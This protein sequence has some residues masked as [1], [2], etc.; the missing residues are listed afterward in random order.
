[1]SEGTLLQQAR[2]L[3][4]DKQWSDLS[5]LA[6]LLPPF[7]RGEAKLY[8]M[9]AR[10]L[11]YEKRNEEACDLLEADPD[12]AT[13]DED[14]RFYF[15]IAL[16]RAGRYEEGLALL[17][18]VVSAQPRSAK[19]VG[20]LASALRSFAKS[21]GSANE[22]ARHLYQ[23][24]LQATETR[25]RLEWGSDHKARIFAARL[26]HDLRQFDDA[27]GQLE[28]ALAS[29]PQDPD[30]LW[31]RSQCL[32]S[33]GRMGDALAEAKQLL[34]IK[35]AHQGAAY[36]V[37]ILQGLVG[38]DDARPPATVKYLDASAVARRS[39]L[40]VL[41]DLGVTWVTLDASMSLEPPPKALRLAMLSAP[42]WAGRLVVALESGETTEL[43]RAAL[44]QGFSASG[45][46]P[47]S[48]RLA[49]D[50]A[51]LAPIVATRGPDDESDPRLLSEPRGE[52]RRVICM[53]RHGIVR[54]GGGEHFLESMAQHYETLG[55]RPLVVGARSTE[56]A[57]ES[58]VSN[59]REY[60]FLP[61]TDAALRR[62]FVEERPAFV[63]VLS[64]LGYEVAAALEFLSIPFVYG[65]HFWRD[66]LGTNDM[67]TRHFAN[68][69]SDP[70]PRQAFRYVISRAA[71]LYANSAYTQ[72]VLEQAFKFRAPIVY[73]LPG[74]VDAARSG[75]PGLVPGVRDYVLLLNAKPEKGFDLL[76]KVAARLP[77]IPFL[78][79]ASQSS[80]DEAL[81]HVRDQGL[82]NVHIIEKTPRTDLLYRDAL[83]VAVPSYQFI[84]TFSRVCIEAHRFGRP[85][86]GSDKGNVPYLL[87]ESGCVL[88]E[89]ADR[90][91]E[92]IARLHDDPA[93]RER[94]EALARENST[95][96]A[97]A[98]QEA[99]IRGIVGTFGRRVL[100]AIGSGVG[101]MLHAG[102]MIRNIAR[103]LGCKV[104]IVV[105]EEYAD[106]LFLL[107]DPEY[108]NAVFSLGRVVLDRYYDVVLVTS[109]FGD[110][111]PT[112]AGRRVLFARDWQ[113]FEP[114]GPLH[115][116][117]YNLET[118]RV[119]L[120]IEYDDADIEGYYLGEIAW[121][122]GGERRLIGFHGGSKA[123]FWVSKRWP[124]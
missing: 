30:A 26:Y 41:R 124:Y 101:N 74:E 31:L 65:V 120:G 34:T 81:A 109:C 2:R 69:D 59:G 99:S 12:L 86:I 7:R 29:K 111:R 100:I 88:P 55:Y 91:A 37:R 51:A 68:G 119:L 44:L 16:S 20:E 50:L 61:A 108:V 35:P 97:Y 10:G 21:L 25:I 82:T 63:H 90:W 56:S 80:R 43:W 83:A 117:V 66:C 33:V 118:A 116:A 58:G 102:P 84:E 105:A 114:G 3:F 38:S 93:Y 4:K 98:L 11:I 73:S 9:V 75:D 36:Q 47:A 70:I 77:H 76:T 45:L 57:H 14:W 106:T 60:A 92:E 87:R 64:G 39:L 62:L 19:Y 1:M 18:G 5:D 110:M 79:V 121:R 6:P 113:K 54:F 78:V 48:E 115:E 13:A 96:Y 22:R 23:Q 112:F 15:G 123:G 28:L 42:A 8:L 17:Q 27:L 85:V 94:R 53:S 71:S 107:H 122:G 24:A 72:A 103:R 49:E 67:D 52:G 40:E 95:R 89:L 32:V 104:D 46:L